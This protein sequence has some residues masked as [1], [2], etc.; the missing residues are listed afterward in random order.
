VKLL[1]AVLVLL[2]SVALADSDPLRAYYGKIV[3]TKIAPPKTSGELPEHLAANVDK[4]G[5]Y[6]LIGGSPWDMN[7]VAVLSK[8]LGASGAVKLVFMEGDKPMHELDLTAKRRLVIAHAQAT[9]AAGFAAH[10]TYELRIT[11]G[12]TVLAK[13]ELRLRD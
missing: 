12:T 13:A 7:L 11:S 4:D 5:M 8:D 6:E 9:T 2:A 3:I 1:A 10:K